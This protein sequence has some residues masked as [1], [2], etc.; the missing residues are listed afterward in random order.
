MCSHPIFEGF[1]EGDHLVGVRR[2]EWLPDNLT[3]IPVRKTESLRALLTSVSL[4]CELRIGK[5]DLMV[6]VDQRMSC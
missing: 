2:S 4:V 3:R 6:V 1:A 5:G